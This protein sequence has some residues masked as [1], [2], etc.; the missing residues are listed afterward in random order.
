MPAQVYLL[1]ISDWKDPQAVAARF[2]GFLAQAPLLDGVAEKDLAAVKLTFGEAGN[3]GHP[4]PALVRELV[5]ALRRRGARPFLTETNTLYAGRRKDS[6][7]HL[8]VARE[9]GFTHETIDAPILMADGLLGRDALE[10]PLDGPRIGT[11]RLAPLLRDVDFL[12]GLAHLTGH[13]LTGLGGAIKNL[14][15]GLANRA[16]KLEMH[17][18]VHPVV[19]EEK[20]TLC[21]ACIEACAHGA[22]AAGARAV[23][24]DGVR[25]TGCAECLAVCPTGAIGIDWSSDA[26][27][28]QRRLAEY[29]LAVH[30]C[31]RGRV[32]CV[33][34]LN[35][36][37]NHCDCIGPT[38][39]RI[40]PD[41]GIAA[42]LDPVALDQ[43]SADLACRAAGT[44]PFRRA[45][46]KSDWEVQ[47]DHAARIGLGSR[48]YELV[49]L[50][51]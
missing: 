23:S 39:D 31:L 38:V 47:L 29:A 51:G 12:V 10:F 21:G 14:G 40:A 6:V 50:S 17:S 45:W 22:I 35:H 3:H 13:L 24:I 30:R 8:Q 37:T 9:H 44:D 18:V 7:E 5:G 4:H 25:C 48:S 16:G 36:V 43:A 15:M 49:E 32:A 2:A 20:C 33:T 42:S 27:E 11:A 34:F 41:V 19:R 46:P 28:V 1:R 26:E